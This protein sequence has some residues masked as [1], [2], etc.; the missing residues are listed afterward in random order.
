[1]AEFKDGATLTSHRVVPVGMSNEV[2]KTI[3]VFSI[4]SVT[5]VMILANLPR[6][7]S[8]SGVFPGRELVTVMIVA[9]LLLG[10]GLG[11]SVDDL[12]P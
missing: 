11:P 4:A 8:L 12:L 2:L 10:L 9:L 7:L 5:L 1:M 3:G 6:S